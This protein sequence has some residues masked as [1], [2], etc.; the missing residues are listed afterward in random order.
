MVAPIYENRE[1]ECDGRCRV[2]KNGNY[3]IAGGR[4]AAA[5]GRPKGAG[6]DKAVY[7]G[8]VGDDRRH[9]GDGRGTAIVGCRHLGEVDRWHLA[10]ALQIQARRAGDSRRRVVADGNLLNAGGK[11]SGA[12]GGP[13]GAGN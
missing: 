2:V 8:L 12:I 5:V 3:L 7:A 13:P 11:V 1:V 10:G 6:Q 9:E 4:V